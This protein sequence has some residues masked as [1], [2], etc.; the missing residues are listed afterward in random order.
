MIKTNENSNEKML[1]LQ[2]CISGAHLDIAIHQ[3]R[4]NSL[5]SMKNINIYDIRI[6]C[7][8]CPHLEIPIDRNDQIS[9][10]RTK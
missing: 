7:I 10:N 3:N 9:R 8:F 4:I 1:I 5:N 6:F 2:F